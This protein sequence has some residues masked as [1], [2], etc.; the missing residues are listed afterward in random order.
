MQTCQASWALAADWALSGAVE[1]QCAIP[2]KDRVDC[3]YP[4][5][6]PEQCNNRGCC[7]DSSI[8]EVP[9]CFKPLQDTGEPYPRPLPPTCPH[10]CQVRSGHVLEPPGP[11][12]AAPLW[13]LGLRQRLHA[14]AASHPFPAVLSPSGWCKNTKAIVSKRVSKSRHDREELT[15]TPSWREWTL[16]GFGKLN[17]SA[18]QPPTLVTCRQVV[19]LDAEPWRLHPT[20]QVHPLPEPLPWVAQWGAR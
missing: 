15:S 19:T 2:A 1:S 13:A 14:R 5:V 7:F 16:R 20:S 6:T 9:W 3:A 17:P 12:E 8:P 10:G 11:Q 4:E 18:H